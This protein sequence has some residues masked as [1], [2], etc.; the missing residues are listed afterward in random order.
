MSKQNL[1]LAQYVRKRNGV[2]MGRSGS[3]RK[4]LYRSLGARNFSTFW[5][6]WNPIFG[7][8]LGTYIFKPLKNIL[9]VS[10]SLLLTF[11][12]N[13]LIHDAVVSLVRGRI[14]LFFTSWFLLMG[15]AVLLAKKYQYDLYNMPWVIRVFV[16]LTIIALCLLIILIL[17]SPFRP[18]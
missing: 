3:L 18:F 9:P 15:I 5:T 10:I 4:N 11:I 6:Y 12:F 7:Y 16:N 13:G 1:S 17:P 2:P 8:Y 14:S